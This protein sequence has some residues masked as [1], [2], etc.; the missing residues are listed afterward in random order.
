MKPNMPREMLLDHLGRA[1]VDNL[2][3]L[4]LGLAQYQVVI[5]ISLALQAQ[6]PYCLRIGAPLA[7]S[8]LHVLLVHEVL[9]PAHVILWSSSSSSISNF[10]QIL[11]VNLVDLFYGSTLAPRLSWYL[12]FY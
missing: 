2:L 9:L 10:D 3:Q 8:L 6:A 4:V 12:R 7:H 5:S 11:D 1:Q